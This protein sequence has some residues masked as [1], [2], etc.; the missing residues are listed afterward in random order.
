MVI[1]K[2][3]VLQFEVRILVGQQST[4]IQCF[5]ILIKLKMKI[6]LNIKS[7]IHYLD[8]NDISC[9]LPINS[10]Y[11]LIYFY[12]LLKNGKSIRFGIEEE[13]STVSL[14]KLSEF[15][16]KLA[17]FWSEMPMDEIKIE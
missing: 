6:K 10:E 17:R 3:L 2:I 12:I 11:K 9:I 4:D 15:R 16:D 13:D 8:T 7:D 14:I 5:F 1:Q